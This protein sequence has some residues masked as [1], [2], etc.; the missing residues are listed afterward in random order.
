MEGSDCDYKMQI[1]S[2]INTVDLFT[3]HC[4]FNMQLIQYFIA[5][6][7]KILV[8]LLVV[9]VVVVVVVIV[10]AVVVNKFLLVG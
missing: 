9:V 5:S 1:S 6:S 4:M 10:I 8:L 3:D 2:W 7:C